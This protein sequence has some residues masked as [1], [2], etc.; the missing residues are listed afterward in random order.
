MANIPE[1]F[2]AAG[3]DLA[4]NVAGGLS[5]DGLLAAFASAFRQTNRLVKL[6]LGDAEEYEQMLLPQTAEGEESLSAPYRYAITCLSPDAALALEP[7]LGQPAR[8]DILTSAG[9]VPDALAPVGGQKNVM[10]CGIVTRAEALPADGGFA[11]Y[12]LILEPPF[13]LL[14]HRRTSRVFQDKAAPDIVKII[15]DEHI[16]GNNLIG[17]AFDYR[18]DIMA[19]FCRE[20]SYCLQYRETDLAFIERLLAEEGLAYRFEHAGERRAPGPADD[21]SDEDETR[22]EDGSEN[23]DEAEAESE[24]PHVTLVVF[25]DAYSLPRARQG[26]IRF[27][28]A[29]ATEASDSLTVWT[30]AQEAGVQKTTLTSYEYKSALTH[31]GE[32]ES[33]YEREKLPIEAMLESY[34]A[35]THY[36]GRDANELTRYARLRQAVCDREKRALQGEGNVRELKAGEW[37]TLT[38]HPL[39]EM[40]PDEN[41][42][43][44]VTRL[45]FTAHSNLPDSVSQYLKPRASPPP[46]YRVDFAAQPRG[47]P[48]HP[49]YEHTKHARFTAWGIET[50]TVT[51]PAGEEEVFTDDMGRIKVQFHWQR[52]QEHPEF[53]AAFDER[54]SC[55][56]RVAYPSAGAGW[57]HQF[58]PRVGQ[59]VVIAFIEGDIDRPIVT[60]VVYNGRNPPP[61]FSGAGRLPAN[62]TLSGIK[63][64]EHDG[65]QYN[66]LLFD[67][68]QNE[69]RTKLSSE[70]GKTQLNQGYLIHPRTDGKGEPR[71]EGFELRTD[72]SGAIRAAEGVLISAHSRRLAAGNQLDREE[73][74][75]QLEQALAVAQELGKDADRHE[76]EGTDTVRQAKLNER[77]KHW[78]DGSNVGQENATEGKAIA[79]LTAPEGI[80]IGT[81][82]NIN[83]ATGES[84]DW[85][86]LKDTNH[87]VG[88]HWRVRVARSLSFFVQQLGM[89]LIAAAGKIVVRA[90]SDEIEIAAAKRLHLI[91]LEEIVLDAPK[92]TLRAQG[93]GVEYGGGITGRTTGAHV[94]HAG[95]H[96]MTG[97]ANVTPEGALGAGKGAFDEKVQLFW[98]GADAPIKNRQYRLHL[99]D[100]RML[101]GATDAEGYGQQ[102]QS[103]LSFARYRV[104]LLPPAASH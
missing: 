100:G 84:L 81:E 55:W 51:G 1:E 33:P 6:Q 77:V 80:A 30:R 28:R 19:G 10:R 53:G 7:L 18:F 82:A 32:D 63:T 98:E 52:E 43:F 12:R 46:P 95:A 93:A 71:G 40:L 57:G 89:K 72:R 74:T 38:G 13:A 96:S 22:D 59:E 75:A 83:L 15:L 48:L 2:S 21:E 68:T 78:E 39:Y 70:H 66:E 27:H 24:L 8:L 9:G 102:L 97:P 31:G 56:L 62:R 85:V 60:G 17:A 86:S 36:Y 91:S 41:R 45:A 47:V 25:N 26:A 16:A 50:G 104:E 87:T 5:L 14:R 101:E 73:L 92:I 29:S 49:A 42:R 4:R 103:E 79:A 37:F 65:A 23:E 94:V 58:I 11:K 64:K 61:W 69:V 54:S 3:G 67:D 20:R 90:L 99:E 76:A 88:Q 34:D 44:T 35:Q